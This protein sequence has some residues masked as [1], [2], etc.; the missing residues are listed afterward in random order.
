MTDYESPQWQT[1]YE[2]AMLER[3]PEVLPASI[4]RAESAIHSRLKSVSKHAK[5]EAERHAL[6]EALSALRVLKEQHFPDWNRRLA[7]RRGA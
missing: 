6:S 2:K 4:A 7:K 5:D 1:L 3:D